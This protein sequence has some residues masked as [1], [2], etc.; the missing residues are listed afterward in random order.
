MFF[1]NAKP[2]KQ[3]TKRA[4]APT[5]TTLRPTSSQNGARKS[6]ASAHAML[7][8]NNPNC[9]SEVET[10]NSSTIELIPLL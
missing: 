8:Q 4:N 7:K 6:G 3:I 1:P 10:P 9:P 5:Y 2:M